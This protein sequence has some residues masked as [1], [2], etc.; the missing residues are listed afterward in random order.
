MLDIFG[1]EFFETNSF[2][3]LCINLTNEKLQY[4]GAPSSTTYHLPPTHQQPTTFNQHAT[5][6]THHAPR[7]AHRAPR[8]AHHAPRTRTTH[9]PT[10]HLP[11]STHHAT[12][13]TPHQ[14]AH[15]PIHPPRYH[16]NEHIF[17]LEAK[18]YEEEG[19]DVGLVTFSTNEPTLELMEAKRS[20]I[21]AMCDEEVQV[22]QRGCDSG[23]LSKVLAKHKDHPNLEKPKPKQLDGDKCFNV[24]HYAATV[25][26]NVTNFVVKNRDT[27]VENLVQVGQ[28]SRDAV[29]H[30]IFDPPAAKA[31]KSRTKKKLVTLGSSFRTQLNS[32]ID[33][34]TSCQPH[35][36][37]CVKPNSA[38][39]ANEFES[40]MVVNQMRCAGLLEVCRIRRVGFPVRMPFDD[41]FSRYHHL[42]TNA[43]THKLLLDACEGKSMVEPT[44]YA[45]GN[46]K[47]FLR[48][49]TKDAL[50]AERDKVLMS[51]ILRTQA[52]GRGYLAQ[53]SYVKY[54]T[55]VDALK[56]AI[57][58]RD[59]AAIQKCLTDTYQLPHRGKKLSYVLEAQELVK[60]MEELK[61]LLSDLQNATR[62]RELSELQAVLEKC[63]A[64]PD[65]VKIYG[66]DR[67]SQCH[68]SNPRFHHHYLN[69]A[70]NK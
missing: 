64:D 16:F 24:V 12:R 19:I 5:R 58:D 10:H 52:V 6:A 23:F 15:S 32:L 60:K 26:Y 65:F 41:F 36:V 39:V 25:A 57:A 66:E 69:Q 46:T 33:T 13:N 8:T 50:E 37:R 7:T 9:P 53:K 17:T 45:I 4:V 48:I 40:E 22:G 14:P 70:I 44:G 31:S 42:D 29:M 27:L 1:F 35:F 51:Y 3:Q 62:R 43:T 21:F 56:A 61:K 28:L 30:T 67:E 55:I 63:Q 38:K 54:R 68:A 49:H 2:E 18:V 47:V 20:G 59:L 34:L 11:L